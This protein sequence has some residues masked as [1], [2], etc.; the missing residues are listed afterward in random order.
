MARAAKKP[1]FP[2]AAVTETDATGVVEPL[3]RIPVPPNRTPIQVRVLIFPQTPAMRIP[4]PKQICT[5]VTRRK[6]HRQGYDLEFWPW[7]RHHRLTYYPD[8]TGEGELVSFI[9]EEH[10]QRWEPYE[11]DA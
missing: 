6:D 9:H 11:G 8:S 1:K 4:G 2:S 10:V 7:I 3:P 5:S